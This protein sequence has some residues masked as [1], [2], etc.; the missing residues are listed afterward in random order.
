MTRG[1]EGLHALVTGGGSGIGFGTAR[2]LAADGA[3][4]TICGA[5]SAA[6]EQSRS[7]ETAAVITR[8]SGYLCLRNDDAPGPSRRAA[9]LL[10][11]DCPLEAG[12]TGVVPRSHRSGQPPPRDRVDDED[13]TWEGN[14]PVALTGSAG[15]VVLFVSDAWHRRLPS[16]PGDPGRFFLQCHYGRRDL[17]QRLRPTSLANQLSPEAV[18]RAATPRERTLVGLHDPSFY[19][20]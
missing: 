6:H 13:L 9:H 3:I 11:M 16:K 7:R 15:D 17:A 12:P 14:R 2:R 20:G 8:K 1:I 10:L 5:A 19:D 18:E 4:V